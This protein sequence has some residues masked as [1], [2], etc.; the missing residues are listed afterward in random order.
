MYSVIASHWPHSPKAFADACQRCFE[1]V[2]LVGGVPIVSMAAGAYFFVGLL[3]HRLLDGAPVLRILAAICFVKA[4]SSTIGPVL[5]IVG[6]QKQVLRF[7]AAALVVKT[8][9]V[10]LMAHFY[11][12]MGTAAAAITVDTLCVA[13]PSIYLVQSLTNYRVRWRVPVKILA[14]ASL[15]AFVSI[16]LLRQHA[17]AAAVLAPAVYVALIFASKAVRIEDVRLLLRRERPL[18]PAMDGADAL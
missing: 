10:A 5:Y 4:V 3:G 12:Y 16:L 2:L 9:A 14:S 11:G 18:I 7:V 6:A 1:T 8:A 17:F 15:A 13:A